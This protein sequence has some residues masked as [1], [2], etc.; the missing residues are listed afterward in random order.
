[1][2]VAPDFPGHPLL[3]MLVFGWVQIALGVGGLVL[4]ALQ[5]MK[6]AKEGRRQAAQSAAD[7]AQ[8][9]F[10]AEM[11]GMNNAQ[12]ESVFQNKRYLR[13]ALK[14]GYQEA[15]GFKEKSDPPEMW[16]DPA[17]AS[18]VKQFGLG[19][20]ESEKKEFTLGLE[21]TAQAKAQRNAVETDLAAD[22]ADRKQIELMATG[23][24][25][26]QQPSWAQRNMGN[27]QTGAE[28]GMGIAQAAQ[29]RAA[30]QQ[31]MNEQ[32]MA[33]AQQFRPQPMQQQTTLQDILWR[34]RYG[35]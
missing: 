5:Q 4:S 34:R 27:I 30:Q 26:Q 17:E 20:M 19:D 15:F 23:P 33:R 14:G 3:A 28:M 1:M 9:P 16:D 32:M 11:A 35:Q 18:K 12:Q 25:Q 10:E 21:N 22:A 13:D 8:Q 7:K 2:I 24:V 29:Q 6:Q 31:A